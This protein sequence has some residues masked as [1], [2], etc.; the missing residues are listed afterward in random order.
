ME[1]VTFLLT[2]CGVATLVGGFMKL[3][4]RLGI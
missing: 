1:P 2:C 4:E 3:V